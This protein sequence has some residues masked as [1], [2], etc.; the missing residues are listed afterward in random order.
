MAALQA[1][2]FSGTAHVAV[3]LIHFF[4][5]VVTFVSLA[6]LLQGR[7][8]LAPFARSYRSPGGE[9]PYIALSHGGPNG[10]SFG[11]DVV[12]ALRLTSGRGVVR[13]GSGG[14]P[15]RLARI[16]APGLIDGIAFDPT[17]AFGHRLIVT[18]SAGLRTTVEAID[19]RGRTTTITSRAPRVEGGMA[20]APAGFGRY[21]GD[22]IAPDEISGRIYAI[23]ARGTTS[24]VTDSGLPHGQDI[25]V[26]SEGFV[27]AGDGQDALLSDRLT[28]HNRHP[29][30]DLILRISQAQLRS[31]GV[32]PG[33]LLVATEGG[34]E[35]D[36]V[37]CRPS[38]CH[39]RRVAVGP[40]VAHAEG[41][42]A[43]VSAR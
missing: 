22:L 43:F 23:T 35:T 32:R 9:E 38:G 15:Q 29:G 25:G 19:C 14:R 28:P 33:D 2:S 13:L 24:L 40:G 31:A 27:P 21:G 8:L 26:E 17:G 12:Y 20:V 39:V 42:I 16:S 30:D 7:E 3:A 5:N 4:Q 10:C 6:G 1:Q 34:A 36:A 18:V 37:S 41:H 11:R